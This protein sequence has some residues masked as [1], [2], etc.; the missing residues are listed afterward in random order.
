MKTYNCKIELSREVEAE[1]KEEAQ[2]KFWE[3][4]EEEFTGQ[5]TTLQIELNDSM[6][7]SERIDDK[8]I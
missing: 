6:E 5:N 1:D 8:T 3:D 4:L 7:V 2:N